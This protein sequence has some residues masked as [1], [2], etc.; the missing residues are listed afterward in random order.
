MDSRVL[1]VNGMAE[2]VVA[3]FLHFRNSDCSIECVNSLVLAGIRK[4]QIVDNSEDG[5]SSIMRIKSAMEE[6]TSLGFT[7]KVVDSGINLGFSAGVNLGIARILENFGPSYVLLINSDATIS[8]VD[9]H[10]LLEEARRFSGPAAIAPSIQYPDGRKISWIYYHYYLG[11]LMRSHCPGTVPHVS[12]CCLLLTPTF[13]LTKHIF[14][15]RFFF[16]GDDVYLGFQATRGE[17]VLNVVTDSIAMH[18]GSVTSRKGS[19]FYEY[20]MARA[21]FELARAMAGSQLSF[22]IAMVGRLVMLSLRAAIRSVRYRSVIPIKG[23][24]MALNDF[25]HGCV[26]SHTPKA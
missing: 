12:G 3:L 9:L 13:V 8:A 15:E 21:H 14:D 10:R 19:F 11:L 1:G 22:A 23:S 20:H 24:I 16:F 2:G 25:L 4:I 5:G 26:T 6:A 17:F 7:I 18:K